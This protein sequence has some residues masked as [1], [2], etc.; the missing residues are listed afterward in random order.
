MLVDV[1]CIP[2]SCETNENVRDCG[3][4]SMVSSVAQMSNMITYILHLRHDIV[5][6]K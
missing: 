4:L 5:M 6:N 2:S 3:F 1:I